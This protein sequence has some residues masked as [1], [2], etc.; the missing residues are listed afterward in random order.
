MNLIGKEINSLQ[1]TNKTLERISDRVQD[2]ET[3]MCNILQEKIYEA[4]RRKRDRK[5][6]GSSD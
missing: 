3:H 4:Y 2:V 1:F 5:L 6:N